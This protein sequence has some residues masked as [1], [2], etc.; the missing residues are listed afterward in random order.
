MKDIHVVFSESLEK[1]SKYQREKYEAKIRPEMGVETRLQIIESI[2]GPI[3]ES[4]KKYVKKFNG[5]NENTSWFTESAHGE[6]F[7]E[8]QDIFAAGDKLLCESLGLSDA[9][10][11]RV[12]GR[13]PA[14]IE[15]LGEAAVR[16][17]KFCLGIRLTEAQAIA[18]VTKQFQR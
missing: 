17:Y 16:E 7:T 4:A 2:A 13:A 6:T 9:E 8:K 10:T 3:S 5:K 1:L 15:K 18:S 12:M 14:E 11:R